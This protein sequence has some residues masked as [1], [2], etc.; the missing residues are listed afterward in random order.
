M[1]N[2]RNIRN[3]WLASSINWQDWSKESGVPVGDLQQLWKD[4]N[5]LIDSLRIEN[6]HRHP[7]E[8]AMLAAR[9][10]VALEFL[11]SRQRG[12]LVAVVA[13]DLVESLVKQSHQRAASEWAVEELVHNGLL[14]A[15]RM[16]R[17]NE[18]GQPIDKRGPLDD[19]MLYASRDDLAEFADVLPAASPASLT[20]I[21]VESEARL[22]TPD[23]AKEYT[24][25]LGALR[26]RLERWRKNHDCDYDEVENRRRNEPRF[27]YCE[28]A[29]IPVIKAILSSTSRP[30][31]KK[32]RTVVD[33]LLRL[34]RRTL[35]PSFDR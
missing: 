9:Q 16:S 4:D 13:F 27:L 33:W 12:K 19:V 20:A 24:V 21:S 8:T 28:S 34:F 1:D 30:S 17:Q 15:L 6:T 29:V 31:Q 23:L 22:S 25:P 18:D 14:A 11:N 26:K 35:R 3:P 5:G 32:R 7:G 2:S 10:A